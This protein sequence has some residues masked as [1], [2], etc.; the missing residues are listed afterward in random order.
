[1]AVFTTTARKKTHFSWAVRGVSSDGLWKILLFLDLMTGSVL[2][3]VTIQ[4][5]GAADVS[6]LLSGETDAFASLP[7]VIPE[8]L[9]I[10][11]R[12][13]LTEDGVMVVNMNMHTEEEGNIN[14]YLSDTI[15]SVF[16][17]VYTVNVPRTTN[18]ELFASADGGMMKRFS[19]GVP[20]VEDPEL[21][22]L[23]ETMSGELA[24]YEDG[25]LR[26]TD[27]KA[28]VELLGMSVIDAII[29]EEVG[30]YR[31]IF[32][33]EGLSGILESF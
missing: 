13:H 16:P 19:A 15:A 5:E 28:P 17:E 29:Q 31:Q 20:S 24:P 2:Y 11:V 26:L 14:Q 10:P 4:S 9:V 23:L 30:Y 1:M 18:R 27:D 12:D 6:I 21:R 3:P 25:G 33:E 22:S 7:N 8:H 32:E